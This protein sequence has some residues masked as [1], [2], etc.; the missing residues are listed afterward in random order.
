VQRRIERHDHDGAPFAVLLVEADGLEQLLAA[1]TGREVA[2]AIE[3]V[4]RAVSEELLPGDTLVR[5]AIGRYWLVAPDTG[6]GGARSLA[7]RVADAVSRQASHRGA[8]M[9]VS[10]GVVVCPEDSDDP[11]VLAGQAEERM[12][13]ARAQ[14]KR[15]AS[16]LADDGS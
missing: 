15:W 9:T 13:A 3:A 4:E 14:G 12:F 8:P 10:I 1:E 11:A 6:I 5:E 7:D 2:T 16:T